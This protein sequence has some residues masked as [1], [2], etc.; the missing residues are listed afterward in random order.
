MSRAGAGA[1]R[2]CDS[3]AKPSLMLCD[4]PMLDAYS[5]TEGLP[6]FKDSFSFDLDDYSTIFSVKWREG[7]G[8]VGLRMEAVWLAYG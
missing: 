5:N 1:V 4:I 2:T 7:S 3:A 8:E 6:I